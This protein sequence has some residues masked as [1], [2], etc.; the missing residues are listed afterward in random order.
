LDTP[1][2]QSLAVR[3]R[4]GNALLA[5]ARIGSVE[6]LGKLFESMRGHLRLAAVREFPR[7][8]RETVSASDL[9]QEAMAT[10]HAR[11]QTF[12]G[13]SP[14][15]FFA[16]MRTILSHAA[17]DR[18]RHEKAA[19]R[20]RGSPAI[21]L[22]ALGSHE[23]ALADSPHARPESI[24]IRGEDTHLVCEALAS[25][26]ADLR[27][28][29]WLRHWEGK[30]FAAIAIELDRSEMAIRKAWCRGLERLE[31]AIRERTSNQDGI[32]G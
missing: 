23:S 27:R 11:F 26:P 24:A 8:I 10:A 28:V 12:R 15:E 29:L 25:L 16:W 7:S 19:R 31:E 6:A 1:M 3:D 4:E 30:P 17:I 21:P 9:V 14:A 2:P 5:A 18:L 13:A 32:G 20:D 22:D